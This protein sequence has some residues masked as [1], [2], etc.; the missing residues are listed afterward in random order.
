MLL[1]GKKISPSAIHIPT[2]YSKVLHII[3]YQYNV[4]KY[5]ALIIQGY[6]TNSNIKLAIQQLARSSIYEDGWFCLEVKYHLWLDYT[7][8]SYH[9]SLCTSMEKQLVVTFDYILERCQP[10]IFNFIDWNEKRKGKVK[11]AD[12]EDLEWTPS[13]HNPYRGQH[14]TLPHKEGMSMTS[15]LSNKGSINN[16]DRI[17][18][19]VINAE[20]KQDNGTSQNIT[21]KECRKY[22]L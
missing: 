17:I 6:D 12:A 11:V 22:C 19:M 9:S 1:Q 10:D 15:N 16:D 14:Y 13:K 2:K 7:E 20:E 4:Y 5:T 8:K 18:L 21:R 3:S